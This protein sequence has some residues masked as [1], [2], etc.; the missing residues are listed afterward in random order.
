MCKAK[1]GYIYIKLTKKIKHQ[2]GL[3]NYWWGWKQLQE[4]SV[5]DETTSD[6]GRNDLFFWQWTGIGAETTCYPTKLPI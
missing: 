6:W 2:N 4:L 3:N 5:G 1:L